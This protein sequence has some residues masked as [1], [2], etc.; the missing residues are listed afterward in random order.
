MLQQFIFKIWHLRTVLAFELTGF[1]RS[2]SELFVYCQET[3]DFFVEWVYS[4]CEER[5]Y[6]LPF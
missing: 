1:V 2:N 6:L 3:L 4:S 5:H